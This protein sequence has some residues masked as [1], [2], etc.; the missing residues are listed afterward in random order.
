MSEMDSAEWWRAAGR[1]APVLA[2]GPGDSTGIADY[3]NTLSVI[4]SFFFEMEILFH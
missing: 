1:T 3:N 4:S 2:K